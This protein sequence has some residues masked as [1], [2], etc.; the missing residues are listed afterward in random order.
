MLDCATAPRRVSLEVDGEAHPATALLLTG[1]RAALRGSHR[2]LRLGAGDDVRV[3]VGWDDG[4]TTSLSGVVRAVA[5]SGP[6]GADD[7]VHVEFSSVDGDWDRLL[8]YVGPTL[9]GRP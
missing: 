8:A 4:A 9:V 6:L 3:V 5:P 1:H 7:L 2:D